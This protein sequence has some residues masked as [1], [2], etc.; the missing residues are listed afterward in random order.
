MFRKKPKFFYKKCFLSTILLPLSW[1]YI[2]VFALLNLRIFKGKKVCK[3]TICVGNVVVGGSGKTP[4]CLALGELLSKHY[5]VCFITK[6]YG[7]ESDK[8]MIVPHMHGKLFSPKE[9]GDEALLLSDVADVFVVSERDDARCQEY[10]VAI[11]DDGFFDSSVRKDCK[12]AV[13]DGNFF[14][15]NGRVLPAGPLRYCL[16]SLKKA[17]FVIITNYDL[18]GV[19]EQVALLANYVSNKRILY[20][21]QEVVSKHDRRA[22]YFA[23]SGIGE[24]SKFLKT[25]ENCKLSVVASFSFE[26][27]TTYNKKK[28]E[29]LKLKFKESGATKMIT[30]SKDFVKLPD[31]FTSECGVEVLEI[32]YEI[33]NVEAIIGFVKGEEL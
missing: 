23:F 2:V 17:D 27:H 14:V 31:E 22:K 6:G 32:K 10:D 24:N 8:D 1:I 3:T 18:A 7:R 12:I 30:T 28:I 13:F 11:C 20:A 16:E 4:I 21:R 26:D 29:F 5:D 15:G 25:L 33:I 9:V 19:E